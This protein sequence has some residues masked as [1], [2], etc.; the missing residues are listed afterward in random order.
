M[1]VPRAFFKYHDGARRCGVVD[2][3]ARLLVVREVP[4][5]RKVGRSETLVDRSGNDD[6]IVFK[7]GIAL[8]EWW[9]HRQAPLSSLLKRECDKAVGAARL[10]RANSV[11]NVRRFIDVEHAALLRSE[12][13]PEQSLGACGPADGDNEF[14]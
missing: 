6:A 1:S 5:H 7:V 2:N 3:A 12:L 14:V 13:E 11:P 4:E 8:W 9:E 10:A